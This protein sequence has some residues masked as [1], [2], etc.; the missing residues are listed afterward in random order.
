M[1]HTVDPKPQNVG[2]DYEYDSKSEVILTSNED[3]D[4]PS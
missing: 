2:L 4:S 3:C 1:S